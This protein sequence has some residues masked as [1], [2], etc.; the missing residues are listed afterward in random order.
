MG[1]YTSSQVWEVSKNLVAEL[2]ALFREFHQ[3]VVGVTT[4]DNALGVLEVDPVRHNRSLVND[5]E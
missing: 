4:Q 3:I 1:L 5:S 2:N